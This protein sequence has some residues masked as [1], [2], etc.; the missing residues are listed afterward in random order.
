VPR[1]RKKKGGMSDTVK[2]MKVCPSTSTCSRNQVGKQ[3]LQRRGH[4]LQRPAFDLQ[5]PI[6]CSC[7]H[8]ILPPGINSHTYQL[9]TRNVLDSSFLTS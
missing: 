3:Y 7:Y 1:T 6:V 4:Q 2:G 5:R 8:C 9:Q